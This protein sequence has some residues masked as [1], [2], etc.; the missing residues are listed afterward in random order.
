MAHAAQQ[1]G[2][3]EAGPVWQFGDDHVLVAVR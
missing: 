2:F 3:A 1:A